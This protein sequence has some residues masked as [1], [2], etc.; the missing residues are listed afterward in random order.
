MDKT[1]PVSWEFTY[2]LDDFSS[3]PASHGTEVSGNPGVYDIP[4]Y[5]LTEDNI[6]NR[7]V[8]DFTI[9]YDSDGDKPVV[10]I[11]SPQKNQTLGGTCLLYTSPSPRD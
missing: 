7:G 10:T 6:G 8:K 3:N 5:I 4:V 9:R 11:I 2:N 1:T